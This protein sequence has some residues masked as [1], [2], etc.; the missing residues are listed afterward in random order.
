VNVDL[1]QT[2]IKNIMADLMKF[3]QD[4]L[5]TRKDPVHSW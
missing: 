5:V 1:I 3:V 4:E 2:I